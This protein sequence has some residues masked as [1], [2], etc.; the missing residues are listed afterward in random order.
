MSRRVNFVD[1][2]QGD[3]ALAEKGKR[4]S[5]RY[6]GFLNRGEK[7]QEN[8]VCSFKLG[9]RQVIAGLDYGVEGMRVGGRRRIEAGPHLAYREAGVAGVVP[10]NALVV[11][12]VEL[13]DVQD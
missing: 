2:R 9:K 3:G 6:D 13:L 11:L 4:V 8:I 5:V 12:E 10:P 1:L 7:F